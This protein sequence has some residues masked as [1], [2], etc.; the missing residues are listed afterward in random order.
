MQQQ[1][2]TSTKGAQANGQMEATLKRGRLF[3]A[4]TSMQPLS[5]GSQ[6]YNTSDGCTPCSPPPPLRCLPPTTPATT[7]AIVPAASLLDSLHHHHHHHHRYRIR[8]SKSLL[9]SGI[10]KQYTSRC[11]LRM[12]F[13][14]QFCFLR[15]DFEEIS[16]LFQLIH[17][18]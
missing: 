13:L 4:S 14:R 5:D 16:L 1:A 8:H 3:V 2:L 15:Y 11:W 7:A 6:A 18:R 17:E 12:M 10:L 9:M